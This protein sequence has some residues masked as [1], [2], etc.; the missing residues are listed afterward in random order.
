MPAVTLRTGNA[1]VC[2][3]RCGPALQE[4]AMRWNYIASQR[5]R[6]AG[7]REARERQSGRLRSDLRALG[8]TAAKRK[9]LRGIVQV[10]IP[11]SRSDRFWEA[12]ILP[13]EYVLGAATETDRGGDPL[14]VVRHLNT[15]RRTRTR[16]PASVEL[17]ESAPAELHRLFDR[18]ASRHTVAGSLFSLW[19]DTPPVLVNPTHAQLKQELESRSPDV[20]H[21]AAMDN[22]SGRQAMGRDLQGARDG[23]WLADT[24]GRATEYRAENIAEVLNAG[25]PNPLF[26]GFDCWDSGARLA[27]MT[28]RAGAASAVGFQNLFDPAIAEV[29]FM[30]FYR[31]CIATQWNLL[32]AFESGWNALADYHG[33]M[34]GGGIVLWSA[35]S[36][37]S[38]KPYRDYQSWKQLGEQRPKRQ[39]SVRHRTADPQRDHISDLLRPTIRPKPLLNYSSLHNGGSVF[40]EF[41]VRLNPAI[42]GSSTSE[43]RLSRINDVDVEVQL[44]VGADTF[45]YRGRLSFDAK[46]FYY[47]F[48]RNPTASPGI[49]LPLTGDL[50]RTIHERIQT[51]LFVEIRWHDQILYRQT[52]P[53]WI[54][55]IDQWTLDERQLGWLPSFVQP[56][57]PAVAKLICDAAAFVQCLADDPTCGFSGYQSYQA[58]AAGLKRWRGVDHQV[59]AIWWAIQSRRSLRYINPPP[60]YTE[61]TQRVRTPTA[62]LQGGFGT[63]VDLALAMVSCLEWVEIHPV[64][65]LLQGH[66]FAGYW[67]DLSAHR[68]FRDVITDDL[69]ASDEEHES[70]ETDRS[71]RW[72]SGPE[73]Y[74]E[75]KGF[76]DRGELIP[77]ETVALTTGTGFWAAVDE[78]REYF[79]KA[80][81]RSFRA[82]IDLVSARQPN[83][84]TPIPLITQ[85]TV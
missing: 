27:P 12:N 68:R 16:R 32:A 11:D 65:F 84:A 21:L 75:L 6:W 50:F 8:L 45:P 74:R 39:P 83:G 43:Q 66:V 44:H 29:F 4:F 37:V 80:R 20:I 56:R 47:D 19:Q 22:R 31:T 15:G 3:L 71:K 49:R 34:L 24:Q 63:C 35:T 53:I 46:T 25:S 14:L 79:Y 13:W 1:E 58:D 55:P 59:R 51:G 40:D 28:I 17:I 67:K 7:D 73:S 54:A 72:V 57:D 2:R 18:S 85:P 52:H 30:A 78:G 33:G 70:N 62:T 76:V 69:P 41:A 81:N 36:L 26:V 60:S 38:G 9:Q 10:T 82:M 23:I 5:H 61:F 48:A 42:F 77:M 64:L